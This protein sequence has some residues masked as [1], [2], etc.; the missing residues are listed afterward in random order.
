MIDHPRMVVRMIL[1]KNIMI[2][3]IVHAPNFH[4]QAGRWIKMIHLIKTVLSIQTRWKKKKDNDRHIVDS[5]L[6]KG[7]LGRK[8]RRH[9]FSFTIS[10]KNDIV[11]LSQEWVN[12]RKTARYFGVC[13]KAI[14][15]WRKNLHLLKV[16][17]YINASAP[18]VNW[19]R[20]PDIQELEEEVNDWCETN[21][22]ENISFRTN[23]ILQHAL[24]INPNLKNGNEKR[25]KRCIYAFMERWNLSVRIVTHV[26][27]SIRRSL[28]LLRDDLTRSV[29]SRLAPGGTL[30][31][32]KPR[33]F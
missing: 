30:S 14:R 8:Q 4:H 2:E 7:S 29:N 20:T 15:N 5:T 18:T 19:G 10:Q 27:Q 6:K 21:L 28:K 25:C 23:I 26:G 31:N 16:K 3:K 9:N 11:V 13:P 17:A 22:M 24:T 12:V 32:I 1:L 33:F